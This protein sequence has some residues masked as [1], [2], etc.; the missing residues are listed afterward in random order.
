[1]V[2]RKLED[3][4]LR[5]LPTLAVWLLVLSLA[6]LVFSFAF[7]Y[8]WYEGSAEADG[9]Y[10]NGECHLQQRPGFFMGDKEDCRRLADRQQEDADRDLRYALAG[11]VVA[12]VAGGGAVLVMRQNSAP[13]R[14]VPTPKRD[15]GGASDRLTQLDRLK[16]DGLL[17]ETEYEAKRREIIEEL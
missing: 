9:V 13:T 11:Y 7:T 17:T 8:R 3:G 16:S 4:F 15:Q 10:S 2:P 6:A 1:M 5:K 14:A 12:L